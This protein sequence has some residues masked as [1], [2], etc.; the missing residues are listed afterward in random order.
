MTREELLKRLSV[1]REDARIV[2]FKA[3]N[4]RS[5]NVKEPSAL[6]REIAKV[7]TEMND[8]KRMAEVK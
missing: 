5:K 3:E 1:L 7:L 6:R 2:R 8:K 4:A